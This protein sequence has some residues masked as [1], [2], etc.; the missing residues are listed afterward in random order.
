[1]IPQFQISRRSFLR[2]VSASLAAT[3]LPLW[4]VELELAAASEPLKTTNS[5]NKRPGIVLIG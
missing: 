2:R 3:G 4:F 5:L 1:M